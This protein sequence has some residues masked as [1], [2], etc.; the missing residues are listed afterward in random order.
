MKQMKRSFLFSKIHRAVVTAADLDY[1]GSLTLDRDLMDAAAL[2]PNQ[3]VDVYNVDR[4]TR[5]ST[6]LIAGDRGSGDCCV[7]GAAAHLC[8]KGDR[9]IICAYAEL[10]DHEIES[11]E[12]RV[13]LVHGDNRRFEMG[14]KER[15][16]TRFAAR[17]A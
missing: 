13:V 7:N 11:H 17:R 6:Y 12:P 9:V 14:Q 16:H 10:E 15:P 8:D 3:R 4:G 2:L 5:L 1:V